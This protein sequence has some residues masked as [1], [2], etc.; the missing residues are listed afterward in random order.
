MG[1]IDDRVLIEAL[2]EV[3]DEP[4]IEAAF[5]TGEFTEAAR[6]LLQNAVIAAKLRH[7]GNYAVAN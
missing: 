7:S 1:R 2:E 4:E 6:A 5:E 3:Q